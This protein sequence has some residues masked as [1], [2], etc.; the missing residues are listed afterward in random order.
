MLREYCRRNGQQLELS[1]VRVT[2]WGTEKTQRFTL[3]ELLN[4]YVL[5][6]GWEWCDSVSSWWTNMIESNDTMKIAIT[7]ELSIRGLPTSKVIAT[8]QDHAVNHEHDWKVF[9]TIQFLLSPY[10]SHSFPGTT[11]VNHIV[12]TSFQLPWKLAGKVLPGMGSN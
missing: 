1:C 5:C 6:G 2:R 8:M 9:A 10:I 4:S 12:S 3:S 11:I 7:M